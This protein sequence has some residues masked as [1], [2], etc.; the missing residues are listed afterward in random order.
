TKPSAKVAPY[1][2]RYARCQTTSCVLGSVEVESL[3]MIYRERLQPVKRIG[4]WYRADSL[5][6]P[7]LP[8]VRTLLCLAQYQHLYWH[9]CMP[10]RC[11]PCT[12]TDRASRQKDYY[13][14]P[15]FSTRYP[16]TPA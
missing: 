6:S 1:L 9:R 5:A 8:E 15:A 4:R 16:L 2:R 3:V 14:H 11:R 12:S 10:C 7:I 13:D